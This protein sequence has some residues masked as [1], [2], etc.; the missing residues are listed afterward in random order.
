M[1]HINVCGEVC[2]NSG[3]C[4]AGNQDYGK[5]SPYK[6]DWTMGMLKME[7]LDG[8][9][10]D[11][12]PNKKKSSSIYFICDEKAGFGYPE[13]Y[14]VSDTFICRAVFHWTTNVTCSRMISS[15][16]NLTSTTLRTTS[17]TA[18]ISTVPTTSDNPSNTTAD[19]ILPASD[20]TGKMSAL[21]RFLIIVGIVLFGIFGYG[22]W[23]YYRNGSFSCCWDSVVPRDSYTRH[24]SSSNH[25]QRRSTNLDINLDAYPIM[26]RNNPYPRDSY[27]SFVY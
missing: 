27:A 21:S 11:E 12:A 1:F 22:L 5:A 10:C 19:S 9:I 3:I 17:A 25:E 14:T 18:T 24:Y 16:N 15:Q 6:L 7:Y 4:T 2:R 26:V 13:Y 23:Y 20:T 8:D